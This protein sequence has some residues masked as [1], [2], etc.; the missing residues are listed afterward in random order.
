M[1][2]PLIRHINLE[3]APE[4]AFHLFTNMIDAW[5]PRGHRRTPDATLIFETKIDGRLF[6]RA[7]DGSEWTM[8]HITKFDPPVTLELDWFP[9]SPQAPTHVQINFSAVPNGSKVVII[10]T[11]LSAK[12][13]NIWGSKVHLFET[14]WDDVLAALRAQLDCEP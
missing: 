8:A 12:A 14:G 9:G 4:R 13:K 11:P 2:E 7:A 5:W 10:H 6:E 1:T 3:C